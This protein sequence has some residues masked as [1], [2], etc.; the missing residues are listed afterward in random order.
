MNEP[1]QE[2]RSFE[3]LIGFCNTFPKLFQM[4]QLGDILTFKELGWKHKEIWA[5]IPSI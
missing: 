3:S 2:V 5:C 1:Q 4:S